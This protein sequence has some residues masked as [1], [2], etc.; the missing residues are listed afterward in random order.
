MGAID[1]RAVFSD[2][3]LFDQINLIGNELPDL[4]YNERAVLAFI[5][6]A[7]LQERELEP[8]DEIAHRLDC[9][10]SGTVRGIM[11]RLERKGYIATESFQRGRR[12]LAKRLGKWTASPKCTVPHWREIYDRSKDATPV[13][14]IGTLKQ[15]PNIMAEVNR[16][17]RE[18]SLSMVNAQ[19]MLM[20]HGVSRLAEQRG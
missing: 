4:P 2:C 11:V 15:F 20:S 17:M 1:S 16:L 8:N 7:A 9:T 18:H 3:T 5:E 19:I 10:G 13:L 6:R 14:P 12:V